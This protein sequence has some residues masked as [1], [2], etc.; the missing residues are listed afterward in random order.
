M[1]HPATDHRFTSPAAGADE[2]DHASLM[3][4]WAQT[5]ALRALA[6]LLDRINQ[7]GLSVTV[8]NDRINVQVPRDLGPEPARAA[9]VAV[10][11]AAVGTHPAHEPGCSSAHDWITADGRLAGHPIHVFTSTDTTHHDQDE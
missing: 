11:A 9:A 1:T 3:G 2:P 6:D 8:D 7:P 5:H 10:L 4:L